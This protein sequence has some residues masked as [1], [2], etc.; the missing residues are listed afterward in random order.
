VSRGASAMNIL[1]SDD[2]GQVSS[3]PHDDCSNKQTVASHRRT[4]FGAA[5]T[6]SE[7]PIISQSLSRLSQREVSDAFFRAS[8]FSLYIS[9]SSVQ[10]RDSGDGLWIRG[11][12][13]VG[14]IVAVYPGIAYRAL[15]HRQIPGYPLIARSNHFL[16][17]R[18][19]GVVMDAKPW[20]D[21]C[22]L[23]YSS[24]RSDEIL[25]PVVDGAM[26][27]AE[28]ALIGLEGRHPLALAHFANHSPAGTL[29]NV[30]VAAV[31]W[32][33]PRQRPEL[34]PYFPVIEYEQSEGGGGGSEMIDC[35]IPGV[36]FVALRALQ[37]EELFLN[38][39]LN[40]NAPG[41]LPSWYSPVDIEEDERRWA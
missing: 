9:P 35:S 13:D 28:K 26:N 21:G 6:P 25:W 14:Q 38:Y 11:G 7:M 4:G 29:P 15:H 10:H 37:D 30:V 18:F 31:N 41:G 17:A 23:C 34:R 20:G 12:A 2:N 5:Q 33:V 19:D 22:S 39:R 1:D 3:T 36:V 8:G 24:S 40:P 32:K 27:C 16:L